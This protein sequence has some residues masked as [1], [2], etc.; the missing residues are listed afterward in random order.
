M[1]VLFAYLFTN[2]KPFLIWGNWLFPL[3]G[4]CGWDGG[5]WTLRWVKKLLL[6]KYR[7]QVYS[8]KWGK[9][10]VQDFVEDVWQYFQWRVELEILVSL[11]FCNQWCATCKSLPFQSCLVVRKSLGSNWERAIELR[12]IDLLQRARNCWRFF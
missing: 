7:L 2:A 4:W 3:V 12:F 6:M 9:K 11:D 10:E 1:S 8:D 5:N